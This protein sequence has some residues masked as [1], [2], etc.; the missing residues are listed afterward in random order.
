MTHRK[1]PTDRS[2][3]LWAPRRSYFCKLLKGYWGCWM[4]PRHHEVYFPPPTR[5]PSPDPGGVPSVA[6]LKHSVY[7]LGLLTG[8]FHVQVPLGTRVNPGGRYGAECRRK[9]GYGSSGGVLRRGGV[10]ASLGSPSCRGGATV[11]AP[12]ARTSHSRPVSPGYPREP[13]WCP[14]TQGRRSR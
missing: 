6:V 10:V 3:R 11:Q 1:G 14:W 4:F 12:R 5:E 2:P 7:R 9:T 13:V 8:N